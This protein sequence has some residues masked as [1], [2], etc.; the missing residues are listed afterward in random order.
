MCGALVQF[1][2]P[3]PFAAKTFQA[4]T[5]DDVALAAEI[6]EASSMCYNSSLDDA[7][8]DAAG[9]SDDDATARAHRLVLRAEE[10]ALLVDICE[11]VRSSDSI[12]FQVPPHACLQR[13]RPRS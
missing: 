6:A 9:G 2:F 11:A 10:L 4:S 12:A 8:V 13:V 7:V 1:L 5:A 3:P